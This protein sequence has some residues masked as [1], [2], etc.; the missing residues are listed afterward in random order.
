M[1]YNVFFSANGRTGI[2]ADFVAGLL[3]NE[4]ESYNWLWEEYRKPLKIKEADTLL[5]AMP[6]YG[7]YIPSFCAELVK[8]LVGNNTPAII[9]AVYG[10]RHFDNALIQAKDLSQT[11]CSFYKNMEQTAICKSKSIS[12]PKEVI[13]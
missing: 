5:F 3:A 13:Y 8:N 6:V 9:M 12:S 2:C 4:A 7:G 11:F 10:N 1:L